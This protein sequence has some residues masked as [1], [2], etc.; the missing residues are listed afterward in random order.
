MCA[1]Q[2]HAQE[3]SGVERLAGTKLKPMTNDESE[4][5]EWATRKLWAMLESI[6]RACLEGEWL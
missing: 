5:H 4:L 3:R 2:R 1:P 6:V